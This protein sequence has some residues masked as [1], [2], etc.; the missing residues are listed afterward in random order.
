MSSFD[1]MIGPFASGAAVTN[2]LE[3]GTLVGLARVDVATHMPVDSETRSLGLAKDSLT[4]DEKFKEQ[5]VFELVKIEAVVRAELL[6][7]E[8]VQ[9]PRF[10]AVLSAAF[11]LYPEAGSE[12]SDRTRV[13]AVEVTEVASLPEPLLLLDLVTLVLCWV[14]RV[15]GPIVAFQMGLS[16][17]LSEE[18][19]DELPARP[20]LPR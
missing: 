20:R 7:A 17:S 12:A 1:A 9:P 4:P 8:L 14:R 16:L 10:P 6:S 15:G 11:L 5:L 2:P 13:A 18:E 3:T 19:E